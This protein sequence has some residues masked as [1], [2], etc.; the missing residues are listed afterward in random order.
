VVVHRVFHRVMRPGSAG[1]TPS[2]SDT[3]I[4]HTTGNPTTKSS[5]RRVDK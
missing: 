2:S 5:E 3:N 1:N 4:V